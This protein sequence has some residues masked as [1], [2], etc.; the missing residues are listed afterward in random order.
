MNIDEPNA[1][2]V[3]KKGSP[4]LVGY[5]QDTCLICS[6]VSG[7]NNYLK[8]YHTVTDDQ[9]IKIELKNNEI[10]FYKDNQPTILSTQTIIHQTLTS[11][12]PNPYPHWTIKE[13]MEQKL[14]C[15]RAL[16]DGGRI[17]NNAEVK[18]GG[19]KEFSKNLL[20]IDNLVILASGTSYHAGL[21][22]S[23]YLQMMSGFSTIRV[24][25]A[26]EFVLNDISAKHTGVLVISQ[27]GETRD[28]INCIELIRKNSSGITIFAIVNV[29]E[30]LISR[31]AD[32]GIYLNAGRE[33]GVASTKSFTNQVIV[34]ILI[35]TWFAQH[36][37]ISISMRTNIIS[38]LR[39]IPD[40]IEETLQTMIEPCKNIV[41]KLKN[42]Q[43]LFI[44]GRDKGLPIALE[45]S[46]KIKELSYIH[47]EGY[48]AGG[49]KHGPL[50]LITEGT[51]V[52]VLRIGDCD[53]KSKMDTAAE[54]TKTRGA[55][56]I[57]IGSHG[58]CNPPTSIYDTSIIIPTDP[59]LEPLLAIIPLQY[60]AY[61]LSVQLGYNPDYPKNLAK[62][63]TVE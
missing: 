37:K 22:G 2:Y 63:V 56:L 58:I 1:L 20:K 24:I 55:Y 9:I 31:M 51:P 26:A 5:T 50:A 42:F 28:V 40:L 52:I 15:A 38:S 36:R 60:I 49:L 61:L 18:L 23:K 35:A 59:Q 48:P 46:L 34:L 29:V 17:Y 12:T 11:T 44:L 62:C 25:D 14:S 7:F 39:N 45:G 30:S 27:S 53:I 6:E 16:N 13:I 54:E 32:C 3:C 4:I 47:A 19:L 10:K 8:T 33:I 57:Q 43:H 21:L 41:N